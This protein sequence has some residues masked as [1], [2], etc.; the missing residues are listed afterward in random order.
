[1]IANIHK[2]RRLVLQALCCL[3]AQGPKVWDLLDL[4]I[5]EADEPPATVS[6]ARRLLVGAFDDRPACDEIL[7]RH[8]KRWELG[9]LAMV[10]RNVLRLAVHEMRSGKTP[11]KVTISESIKLAQEFSSA[12]S[13]RFVNGVLDSVMRELCP[14]GADQ[15]EQAD[16]PDQAG[17]QGPAE[18]P[19]PPAEESQ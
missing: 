5:G 15:H 1:M 6:A 17:R 3:D 19:E 4:F 11:P 10:D 9:R 8:A 7:T 2:A 18:N 13:P 12:E 14:H 16:Q